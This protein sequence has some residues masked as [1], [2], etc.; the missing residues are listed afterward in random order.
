LP[1][2][3]YTITV[4]SF[5]GPIAAAAVAA[6]IRSTGSST[7]PG[8][9]TSL[10]SWSVRTSSSRGPLFAEAGPAA[11]EAASS[12][13]ASLGLMGAAQA[14]ETAAKSDK[15]HRSIVRLRICTSVVTQYHE[16]TIY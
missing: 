8:M 2:R 4:R 12:S 9:R 10:N 15:A 13:R 6:L 7:A 5:K 1:E 11:D 14:T 3:Q 16:N